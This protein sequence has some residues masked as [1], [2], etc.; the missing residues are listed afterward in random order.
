MLRATESAVRDALQ[1]NDNK[2]DVEESGWYDTDAAPL[3][4]VLREGPRPPIPESRALT[5]SRCSASLPL[6]DAVF[7]STLRHLQLLDLQ[8]QAPAAAATT[9]AGLPLLEVNMV[10]SA[11]L[12]YFS[13]QRLPAA[14][15]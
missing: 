5:L 2:R 3:L 15:S 4:A 11:S 6:V 8:P 7:G 1:L 12:Y 14:Y 10:C 9:I 13:C